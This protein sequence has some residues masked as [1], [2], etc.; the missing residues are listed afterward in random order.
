VIEAHWLFD[1]AP[2]R[3]EVVIHP[4]SIVHALVEFCD[5]SML[6][7]LARADM[8]GP[9]AYA[10]E[11]P[12]RLERAEASL[13]LAGIGALEFRAPRGRFARAVALAYRAIRSGGV[14]GAVLNAANEAAVEAFLAG[15]VPFGRIVPLAEEVLNEAEDS[16]EFSA[17]NAD[18]YGTTM[19]LEG[20]LRAD[21]WARRRVAE[22]TP[23]A[24]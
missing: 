3:I 13:D 24:S 22:L 12:N 14:A 20:L 17:R 21:E 8:K 11:Y 15:A 6:A 19:P 2:E 7:Q 23:T 10:L 16:P 5:G 4:Q 18:E 1:L 9:I